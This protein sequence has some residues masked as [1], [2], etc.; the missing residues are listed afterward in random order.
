MYCSHDFA[1]LTDSL[2]QSITDQLSGYI[3]A[4]NVTVEGKTTQLLYVKFTSDF[5][6]TG[7]GFLA[8]FRIALGEYPCL[9]VPRG[10]KD[11]T[12]MHP[13]FHNVIRE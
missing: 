11:K 5:S 8:Q 12:K 2:G 7:R 9:K 10:P 6:V 4:F 13:T 1:E 3:A